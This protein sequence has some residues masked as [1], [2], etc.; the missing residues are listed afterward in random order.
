MR[1]NYTV[2]LVL[3]L[4]LFAGCDN[5]S[6]QVTNEQDNTYYAL[7]Y[8]AIKTIDRND[9][10]LFAQVSDI[11]K[12]IIELYANDDSICVYLN[13]IRI[14][15]DSILHP[16]IPLFGNAQI[17]WD[18]SISGDV[19]GYVITL[20][21]SK[22]RLVLFVG[23]TLAYRIDSLVYGDTMYCTVQAIDKDGHYSA[24]SEMVK[25][26]VGEDR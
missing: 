20:T 17:S 19:V 1:I 18:A 4:F 7:S 9:S 21:G 5:N 25:F 24:P 12:A 6:P 13:D 22:E 15:L 26:I 2:F 10:L 3:L 11:A 23:D 16:P 14:K 8:S